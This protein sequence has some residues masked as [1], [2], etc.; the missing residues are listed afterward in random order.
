[1]WMEMFMTENGKMI[2]PMDRVLMFTPEEQN[3]M[4]NGRMIYSMV[5]GLKYGLMELSIR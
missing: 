2:W 4:G 3:M 1:M 5:R